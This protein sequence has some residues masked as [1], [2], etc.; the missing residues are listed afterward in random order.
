MVN[1]PGILRAKRKARFKPVVFTPVE[2][3]FKPQ[4]R[5]EMLKDVSGWV[6]NDKSTGTKWH[7]Q[8]G[9]VYFVDSETADSFIV[10]GYAKGELSRHY[11]DD[12]MAQIKSSVANIG[13]GGVLNG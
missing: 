9:K 13:M 11:S 8:F 7:M 12:E 2:N 4:H 3:V 10:K 1:I 5:I 6:N